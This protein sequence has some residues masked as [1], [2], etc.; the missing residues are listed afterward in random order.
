MATGWG[1]VAMDLT[2]VDAT[3]HDIKKKKCKHASKRDSKQSY[4]Y[5]YVLAICGETKIFTLVFGICIKP[6]FSSLLKRGKLSLV[7]LGTRTWKSLS[8]YNGRGSQ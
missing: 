5:I 1:L 8:W 2:V 6:T 7:M 3:V 4:M